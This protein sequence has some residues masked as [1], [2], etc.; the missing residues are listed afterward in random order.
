MTVIRDEDGETLGDLNLFTYVGERVE[1]E[2]GEGA[3]YH[4]TAEYDR[5]LHGVVSY[6]LSPCSECAS[7]DDINKKI[8]E[9][10]EEL[11]DLKGDMMWAHLRPDEA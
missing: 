6:T 10:E 8:K 1:L 9:L 11:D 2:F 3:T 7:I 4:V 5:R